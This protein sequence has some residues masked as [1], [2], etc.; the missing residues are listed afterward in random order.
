MSKYTFSTSL[1]RFRIISFIEGVSALLLFFVAMPIKYIGGI[2]EAVKYPGWVHGLLFVLY[3][4]IMLE[5][6]I[7]NRWSFKL[8]VLATLASIIPF[9]PFVFDRYFLTEEKAS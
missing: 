1:G 3:I 6:A 5:T 4:F 8:I 7:S 9:G 2:P